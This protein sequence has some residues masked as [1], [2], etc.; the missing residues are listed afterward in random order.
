MLGGGG[1]IEGN[2]RVRAILT[3]NMFLIMVEG[4]RVHT[5]TVFSDFPKAGTP[6]KR[7]TTFG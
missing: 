2:E 5:L 3:A 1:Y 4:S 7:G 6:R